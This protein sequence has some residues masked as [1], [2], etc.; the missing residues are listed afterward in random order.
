MLT[1]PPK[2]DGRG[3]VKF[4]KE[5]L[6]GNELELEDH[7]SFLSNVCLNCDTKR[8]GENKQT[9]SISL[10]VAFQMGLENF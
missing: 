9:I 5:V 6:G 1:N 4:I 3:H 10:Q 8:E 2:C 7:E